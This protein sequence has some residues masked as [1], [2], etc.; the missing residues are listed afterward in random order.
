[1]VEGEDV[2]GPTRVEVE[3]EGVEWSRQ[4]EFEEVGTRVEVTSRTRLIDRR[5]TRK[6]LHRHVLLFRRVVEPRRANEDLETLASLDR[7]KKRRAD[8]TV[9][10]VDLE[11]SNGTDAALEGGQKGERVVEALPGE[12][13][14]LKNVFG[15]GND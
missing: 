3:F 10:R 12:S 6:S 4:G 11:M 9:Q 13:T 5:A 1:V 14:A 7:C 15:E 2:S 8:L